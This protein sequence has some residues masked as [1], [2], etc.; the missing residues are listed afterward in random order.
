MFVLAHPLHSPTFAFN[1][2]TLCQYFAAIFS[3]EAALRVYDETEGD[4]AKGTSSTKTADDSS[5][6]YMS[7]IADPDTTG[8]STTSSSAAATGTSFTDASGGASDSAEVEIEE[9]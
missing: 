2:P 8:S 3:A 9:V 1:R 4:G 5:H 6:F 7:S